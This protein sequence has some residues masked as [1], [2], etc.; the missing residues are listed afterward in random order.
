MSQKGVWSSELGHSGGGEG[1]VSEPIQKFWVTF[2]APAHFS[3]K[4]LV[5]CLKSFKKKICLRKSAPKVPK[6]LVVG[7]DTDGR[8][9][10][11]AGS[12]SQAN[13]RQVGTVPHPRWPSRPMGTI[14]RGF[15]KYNISYLNETYNNCFKKNQ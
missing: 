10:L 8:C 14:V 5:K 6:F 7:S 13:F 12:E 15:M 3:P 1:G 11:Q 4:F 9:P 2:C